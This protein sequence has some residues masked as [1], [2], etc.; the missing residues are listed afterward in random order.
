M[1]VSKLGSGSSA[2]ADPSSTFVPSTKLEESH[3]KMWWKKSVDPK[4]EEGRRHIEGTTLLML[5]HARK[6][7]ASGGDPVKMR[8]YYQQAA[9]LGNAEAQFHLGWMC[10][11]GKGGA[12]DQLAAIKWWRE[13]ATQGHSGAKFSLGKPTVSSPVSHKTDS[14]VSDSETENPTPS[15]A[16]KSEEKKREAPV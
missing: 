4:T 3:A 12:K 8:W 13:A 5:F 1:S 14:D 2:P 7:S 11:D 16:K 6:H 9:E 10:Q 15:P